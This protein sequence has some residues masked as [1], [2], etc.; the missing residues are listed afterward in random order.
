VATAAGVLVGVHWILGLAV[1]LTWLLVAYLTRY[2]SLSALLSALAAP[3]IYMLGNRGAWYTDSAISAM[4]VAMSALLVWRHRQ[5]IAK[6]MRGEESR[7][8]AKPK[9]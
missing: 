2:S 5:N 1:L 4:L 9:A 6:L 3:L 7:I 8:G